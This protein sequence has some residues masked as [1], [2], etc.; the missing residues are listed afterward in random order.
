MKLLNNIFSDQFSAL[1]IKESIQLLR[2]KKIIFLIIFPAILR[3]LLYGL[4]WNP[5]VSNL[6]LGILDYAN[7]YQSQVLVST[8][9][10]NRIF[11]AE[12]YFLK[13]Q[14]LTE[15]IQLG[16][17]TV[18]LVIPPDFQQNLSQNKPIEVQILV[19]GV[20][21]NQAAI[22][23]GYIKKLIRQY[24]NQL[25]SNRKPPLI[26]PQTTFLYNPRLKSSWFF[27]P[28]VFGLTLAVVTSLVSSATIIREKD[29]GTLEQLL[30][31]PAKEWEILLAKIIPLLILLM[32]DL[33]LIL[34]L[35]LLVFGL[36]FRGNLLLFLGLSAVYILTNIAI[37]T[38]LA[39]VSRTQQQAYI[40]SFFVNLPLALLSGVLSPIETMPVFFKYLSLFNPLRHYA[41]IIRGI[42]LKGVGLEVLW[43]NAIALIL[44]ATILLS[45]SISK[46]RC[47]L[48]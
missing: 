4:A 48:H 26:T 15:Q 44:F 35:A 8:L 46:F 11:T 34:C 31:T 41:T 25:K 36:P 27:V 38:M 20:D 29:K 18:G 28:G 10:E 23:Q 37:G 5:D 45:I 30:M 33:I 47:Q 2:D 13:D 14:K 7:T 1:A 16:K 42:L 3:I 17:L 12:K 6:K 21:A 40:T 32:G 9:T 39:T 43:V 24:T 19:D 22:A